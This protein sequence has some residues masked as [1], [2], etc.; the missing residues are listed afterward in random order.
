ME[1]RP[2]ALLLNGLSGFYGTQRGGTATGML[3]HWFDVE[4]GFFFSLSLFI[5]LF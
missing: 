4:R 2:A 5:F 1:N 3:D